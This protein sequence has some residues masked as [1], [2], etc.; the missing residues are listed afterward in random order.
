MTALAWILIVV[1]L[2]WGFLGVF[3]LFSGLLRLSEHGYGD[4]AKAFAVIFNMFVLIL[5]GLGIA[6]IGA[7]VL[8]RRGRGHASPALSSTESRTKK[9]PQC[10]EWIKL[11]AIVCRYCRYQFGTEQV[12]GRS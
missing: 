9:C 2:G 10:A 6:G 1:G 7:M 4:T 3:N 12:K 11:E 8:K 5:P